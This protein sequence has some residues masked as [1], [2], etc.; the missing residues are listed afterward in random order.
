MA[1][2][3]KTSKLDI[4]TNTPLNPDMI[5]DSVSGDSLNQRFLEEQGNELIAEKELRQ[6]ENL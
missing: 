1:E 5:F 4:K 3:R 2:N 6:Q